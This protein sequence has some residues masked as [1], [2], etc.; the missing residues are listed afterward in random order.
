MYLI[1]AS[2]LGQSLVLLVCFGGTSESSWHLG[3]VRLFQ[4]L[5]YWC[6]WVL[7]VGWDKFSVGSRL[8]VRLWLFYFRLSYGFGLAFHHWL[9]FPECRIFC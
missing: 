6:V 3:W 5:C 1:L 7:G 4:V 8:L 2:W 9:H